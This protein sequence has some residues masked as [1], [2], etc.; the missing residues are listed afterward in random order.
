[1]QNF[2]SLRSCYMIMLRISFVDYIV[3]TR[4]IVTAFLCATLSERGEGQCFRI[5]FATGG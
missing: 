4:H 2:G 3:H 5:S 1:M